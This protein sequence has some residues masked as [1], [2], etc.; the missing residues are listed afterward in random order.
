[1]GKKNMKGGQSA[2]V[3]STNPDFEFENS[4]F[5]DLKA[6]MP[7][8]Q[9]QLR[10]KIDRKQRN[11]KEVSLVEG[12]EGTTEELENLGRNLKKTCGVG[13][14]VKDGIILIQGNH[15]DKIVEYLLKLGYKNTK[16][17]GG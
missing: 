6:P 3:Y 13:G 9:Q 16:K 17:S 11:G 15:R 4:F 2:M 8:E 7:K 5:D 14:S 12:F 10:V 1:M